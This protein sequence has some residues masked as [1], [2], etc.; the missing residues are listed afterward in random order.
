MRWGKRNLQ[1]HLLDRRKFIKNGLIAAAGLMIPVFPKIGS[2]A[3]P[4]TDRQLRFYHTHTGETLRVC[5]WENGEYL[6][7]GLASINHFFRDFRNGDIK[8]I[9]TRLVDLLHAISRKI[10]GDV[11]FH[12]IS[13]YRSPE[14]NQ[15]LRSKSNGVAKK[16]LHMEGYAADIRVP[17]IKTAD[18]RK[19]A[20]GIGSG[21]VGYYPESDFVHVDIGR[22]R[23]W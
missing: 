19:I 20:I 14:T 1:Q 15:K 12:L 4:K 5:Y 8:T 23:Q 18:L 6:D 7:S 21:G 3:L 22:V 11:S 16:S 2:A 17:G 9:D 13:G 10:D